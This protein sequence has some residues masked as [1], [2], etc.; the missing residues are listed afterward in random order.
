M[1]SWV[2]NVNALITFGPAYQNVLYPTRH[3]SMACL[4]KPS[5]LFSI[6]DWY[7]SYESTTF[8]M[9]ND[10]YIMISGLILADDLATLSVTN[11]ALPSWPVYSDKGIYFQILF[12]ISLLKEPYITLTNDSY[13]MISGLMLADD[14][15][16]LSVTNKAL[17]SWPV[18][19]DK[20]IYF[21]TRFS[22]NVLKV[23][24]FPL[25]NDS[26]IMISCLMLTDDLATSSVTNTALPPWPVY[27]DNVFY[28]QTPFSISLLKKTPV[29]LTNDSYIMISGLMWGWWL[30]YTFC[31]QQGIASMTCLS[32]QCFLFSNSV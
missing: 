22:I 3:C 5:L 25:T 21:K 28:F 4:F 32:R 30:S 16:T 12:S 15:A 29:P 7:L 24:P 6:S 20:G 31:N 8:S 18:Y 13:I 17:P 27:S 9:A 19:S 2:D 11:K 1:L 14:L 26:Y 23:S 10:S